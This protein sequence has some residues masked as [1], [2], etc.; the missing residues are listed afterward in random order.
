MEGRVRL[1]VLVAVLATAAH[2]LVQSPIVRIAPA[3][4]AAMS[5]HMSAPTK[6]RK[7]DRFKAAVKGVAI[8]VSAFVKQKDSV[9]PD[10]GAPVSTPAQSWYDSGLR[11]RDVKSLS[12]IHI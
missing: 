8:K 11:L 3:S 12:L 9:L 5:M 2:A 10:A 1:F 4:S 6:L 7:R